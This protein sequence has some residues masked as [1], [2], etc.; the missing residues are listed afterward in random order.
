MTWFPRSLRNRLVAIATLT[1]F[2]V[3]TGAAAIATWQIRTITAGAL[4][5]AARTRLAAVRDGL[6]PDGQLPSS[7]RVQRTATY[8]QVLGAD[9]QVVSASP[10]LNDAPALLPIAVARRGLHHPRL[11]NLNQPDLDLA[12]IA[13]PVSVNGGQGAVIVGVDSQG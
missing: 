12:V 13:E 11:L 7:T 1:T 9:G 5:D 2:V 8:V 4:S 6:T 10:A 3:M